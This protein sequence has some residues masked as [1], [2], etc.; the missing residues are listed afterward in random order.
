MHTGEEPPSY[1]ES[2]PNIEFWKKVPGYLQTVGEHSLAYSKGMC[3]YKHTHTEHLDPVSVTKITGVHGRRITR[4]KPFVSTSC[5]LWG[6]TR[7]GGCACACVVIAAC[8]F[9]CM[10]VLVYPY[11]FILPSLPHVVSTHTRT[12]ARTAGISKIQEWREEGSSD[13]NSAYTSTNNHSSDKAEKG[14]LGDGEDLDDDLD[15]D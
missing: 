9:E 13:Q 1:I 5:H 7:V 15:F 10:R 11:M 4:N 8:G 12:H 14:L 3:A 2:I 6:Y